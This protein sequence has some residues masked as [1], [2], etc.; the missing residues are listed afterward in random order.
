MDNQKESW[1]RDGEEF[2]YD[3]LDDLVGSND[4]LKPGDRVY[5]GE[6]VPPNVK[7][8][9]DANDVID[10]INDRSYDVGGEYAEG[11]V[12]GISKEA[13]DELDAFLAAWIAKNCDL[14]F[15]TVK[16]IKPYVLTADDIQEEP[17]A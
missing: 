9:C 2:R 17:T 11:C 14:S 3:D 15:Y 6:A 1:S 12:D 8:L 10:T 13:R 5:V 7:H 4:D 16:N